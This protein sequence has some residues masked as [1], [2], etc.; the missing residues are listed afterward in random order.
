MDLAI[1]ILAAGKSTRMKS[2]ISKILHK[3]AGK[4]MIEYVLDAAL[5]TLPKKIVVVLGP[6]MGDVAKHVE[7]ID[8][9]IVTCVQ[10]ERLGTGHAV[11]TALPALND[12]NGNIVVACGDTPLM[13]ASTLSTISSKLTKLNRDILIGAFRTKSVNQYGRLIVGDTGI[14]NEIVEFKEATDEQ[15]CI[16]LC[17][18]AIISIKAEVLKKIVMLI[19]NNNSKGEYYLTDIVKL[20]KQNGYHCGYAEI[21]KNEVVGVNS[22]SELA[23]AEKIMQTVLREKFM[24]QGVTLIDPDSVTFNYDTEIEQ[25]VTIHPHV[26]FGKAVRIASHVEIKSFSHLEGVTIKENVIIGP[27]AR[28]RPDTVIN[29][30]VHIGNFVEIKNS[31]IGKGTKANHLSYVGDA[32]I[33]DKTNIGAGTITANYDGFKKYKTK[34]GDNVSVGSNTC[35]VAPV[36]VASG[37][38][39]GA[40][41]VITKDVKENDLVVA[42]AEQVNLEGKAEVIRKRKNKL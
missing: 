24:D 14:V 5:A 33:G 17:N 39:I 36:S 3:I 25:D 7:S 42:R 32:E 19:D 37:S 16:D 38:I 18:S 1:I 15:K 4:S 26:V 20:A 35:L 9:R 29:E 27:Y 34:I 22:R 40:G 31:V 41:S 11:R 10:E 23:Q 8:N 13:K 28:I 2:S 21:D 30:N 12:F 6:D